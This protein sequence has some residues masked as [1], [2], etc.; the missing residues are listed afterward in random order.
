MAQEHDLGAQQSKPNVSEIV[1]AVEHGLKTTYRH[2]DCAWFYGNEKE[3]R[4]G[5]CA[6]GVPREEVFT[7]RGIP[8]RDVLI[9]ESATEIGKKHGLK[10]TPD[11]LGYLRDIVFLP[12]GALEAY[13]A[14]TPDGIEVLDNMAASGKQKRFSSHHWGVELGSDNRPAP[15][16]QIFN[17]QSQ[18]KDQYWL[19]VPMILPVVLST[20]LRLA[21]HTLPS[22]HPT[23]NKRGR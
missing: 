10:N 16:K 20:R 2:I 14:L 5:L 19:S 6:S 3:V 7:H 11:V 17:F 8:R 22:R 12:T 15:T 23:A 1:R 21:T 9:D 13:N 18:T 4:K